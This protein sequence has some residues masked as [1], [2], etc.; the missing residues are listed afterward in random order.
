M[1]VPRLWPHTT[2]LSGFFLFFLFIIFEG[3]LFLF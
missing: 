2:S 3:T 1:A